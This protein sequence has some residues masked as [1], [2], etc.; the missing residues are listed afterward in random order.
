MTVLPSPQEAAVCRGKDFPVSVLG[1]RPLGGGDWDLPVNSGMLH[2]PRPACRRR[3]TAGWVW[4][5]GHTAGPD[6]NHT[7]LPVT[8]KLLLRAQRKLHLKM[9]RRHKS[10]NNSHNSQPA[11]PS[12]GH[13]GMKY[14]Y[15]RCQAVKY[16]C[17]VASPTAIKCMRLRLFTEGCNYLFSF[18]GNTYRNT[19]FRPATF[20]NS[21]VHFYLPFMS[22]GTILHCDDNWN[23][24][25][26]GHNNL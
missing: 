10:N 24:I 19:L 21:D 6:S 9:R 11:W 18:T 7:D 16:E 13:T 15:D 25:G 23:H 17:T 5:C 12:L 20:H 22:M 4:S 3:H 26:T 2:L 8:L 14:I 1:W